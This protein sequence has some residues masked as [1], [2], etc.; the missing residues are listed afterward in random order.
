MRLLQPTRLLRHSAA[1]CRSRRR[2][3]AIA[4]LSPA[5][6]SRSS[7]H[8]LKSCSLEKR[9]FR[10]APRLLPA[11]GERGGQRRGRRRARRCRSGV[12]RGRRPLQAAIVPTPPGTPL[13][14]DKGGRTR[15]PTDAS[16][17]PANRKH[18]HHYSVKL[19]VLGVRKALKRF[20]CFSLVSL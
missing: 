17:R 16:D 14:A 19:K 6:N 1:H 15:W 8:P 7:R 3:R 18:G 20:C 9:L 11:A 2:R 4:S 10:R 13:Y 12:G 5:S